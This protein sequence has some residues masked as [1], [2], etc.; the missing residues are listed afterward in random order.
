MV[1]GHISLGGRLKR[2]A[3][4]ICYSYLPVDTLIRYQLMEHHTFRKCQAIE[5]DSN[6]KILWDIFI[7]LLIIVNIFY[8]PMKL[9]F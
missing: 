6:F 9:A 5:P 2:K 8:L 3:A 4:G 7:A 1:K